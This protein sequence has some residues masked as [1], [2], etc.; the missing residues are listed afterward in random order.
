[1]PVLIPTIKLVFDLPAVLAL[2]EQAMT[3]VLDTPAE[4]GVTIRPISVD[5][6]PYLYLQRGDGVFLTSTAEQ[7]IPV[8]AAGF[9]PDDPS[10]RESWNDQG[11]PDLEGVAEIPLLSSGRLAEFRAARRSGSTLLVITLTV[12][13]PPRLDYY[14]QPPDAPPH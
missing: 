12:G 8:Y 5:R 1:V 2:A 4:P 7:A 13:F 11:L 14:R 10:W 6:E 9:S 3:A